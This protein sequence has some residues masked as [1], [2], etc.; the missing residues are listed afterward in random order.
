[1]KLKVVLEKLKKLEG[2]AVPYPNTRDKELNKKNLEKM[3]EYFS[4]LKLKDIEKYKLENDGRDHIA[5]CHILY[6]GVRIAYIGYCFMEIRVTSEL[7][8]NWCLNVYGQYEM[9]EAVIHIHNEEIRDELGRVRYELSRLQNKEKKLLEKVWPEPS[10]AKVSPTPDIAADISKDRLKTLFYNA[11]MHM[12]EN[13]MNADEI[14][15]YL[16]S[17]KNELQSL[18]VL[19]EELT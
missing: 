11:V 14:A 7:L 18:G 9:D 6:A 1:M 2:L 19:E 3:Q 4:T 12:S 16:G 17:D 5:G 13:G 8:C 10:E 15:E